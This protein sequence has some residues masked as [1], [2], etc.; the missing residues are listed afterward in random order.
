MV[1]IL[2]VRMTYRKF[3]DLK[4]QSQRDLGKFQKYNLAIRPSQGGFLSGFL[5][6]ENVILFSSTKESMVIDNV[7]M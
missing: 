6:S 4:I 2:E 5:L 1:L 3:C 7:P